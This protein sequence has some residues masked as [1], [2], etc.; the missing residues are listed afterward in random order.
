MEGTFFLKFMPFLVENVECLGH[1]ELL[2]EI[3]N[4]VVYHNVSG[5]GLGHSLGNFGT[6]VVLHC[7]DSFGLGFCFESSEVVEVILIFLAQ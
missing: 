4:E 2:H 1:F 3:A 7:R 6:L 5:V